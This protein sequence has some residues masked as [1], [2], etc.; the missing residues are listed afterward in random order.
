MVK[1]RATEPPGRVALAELSVY[2]FT[3]NPDMVEFTK[4]ALFD[5][6]GKEKG[7]TAAR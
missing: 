6:K 4:P 2:I 1:I 7:F 3:F 5:L